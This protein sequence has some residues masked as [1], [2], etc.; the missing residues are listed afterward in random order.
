RDLAIEI[1]HAIDPNLEVEVLNTA[2][3]FNEVIEQVQSGKAHIGISKL[4]YTQSRAKRVLYITPPYVDLKVSFL[5]DRLQ[6]AKLPSNIS[7]GEIFSKEHDQTLCVLKASSQVDSAQFLLPHARL[8]YADSAD[9]SYEKLFS[10]QCTAVFYD[11]NEFRLKLMQNPSLNLRYKAVSLS[12]KG[13]PI[14]IVVNSKLELLA[15]FISKQ[16]AY[17]AFKPRH[18]PTEIKKYEGFLK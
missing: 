3:T 11:D 5:I 10:G 16:F 14:S 8:V 1:A 2:K 7:V 6:L 13:D 12:D 4:S 18:L 9:D 17:N 15:R